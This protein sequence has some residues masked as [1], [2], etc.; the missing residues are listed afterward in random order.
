MADQDKLLVVSV[1]GLGY[2][3]LQSQCAAMPG[4]ESRRVPRAFARP[5]PLLPPFPA[6]T[7]TSQATF[8]TASA[9]EAHGMVANGFYDRRWRKALFWEQ[10]SGLVEGERI[11]SAFRAAGKTV[12]LLF[13]QQ[14]MGEDA[15]LVLTP[16]PI[17]K[18]HGGMI[19]DCYSQPAALYPR[20]RKALGEFPLQRYWGPLASASV[21]NWIAA[22]TED[23]MRHEAPDLL[24]TYLPTLDY[25]LQR[26]GPRSPQASAAFAMVMNQLATLF[27]AAGDCGYKVLFFG[28]YAIAACEGPAVLPN[29]A[30]REAG[31]M[32]TREV[33]GRLYPDFHT[34]RAFAVCDHEVAH[35][36]VREI[37]DTEAVRR[38]LQ[39]V[40]GIDE[41]RPATAAHPNSGELVL[42][43]APGRWLAYPWWT[44]AGEAPEYARHI[45]IHSKP[46]FDPCDLYAT[47]FP[48]GVCQDTS[49]I[50]G[51]H[52]RAD[53]AVACGGTLKFDPPPATLQYLADRVRD[54][55]GQQV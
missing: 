33:R 54:W 52:G 24:L 4:D 55:L 10:S 34:S 49:R 44:D 43:A 21:G 12:G 2:E 29:L 13:W 27:F 11:W 32:A 23:V 48:P 20:L 6:V 7:C 53:R 42:L 35:V 28:D 9:P 37:A 18:H 46:G 31:L 1:A 50:R 25:D 3:F 19:L 38:C 15:D 41:V 16:A 30:L 45:D 5:F 26:H 47:W 40:P 22:A 36:Y 8:R 14:A 17:H 51:T 39:A